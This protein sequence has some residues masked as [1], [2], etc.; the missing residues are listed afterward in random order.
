MTLD[1]KGSQLSAGTV[2]GRGEG[3]AGEVYLYFVLLLLLTKFSFFLGGGGARVVREVG[4]VTG[5][6]HFDICIS[7][8]GF[9]GQ[10]T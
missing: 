2:F 1:S 7:Q 9:T 4:C 6:W 8:S 10:G 5:N 3:E